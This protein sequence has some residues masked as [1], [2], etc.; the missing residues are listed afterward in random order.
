MTQRQ[1][2]KGG[3]IT[4]N[5]TDPTATVATG[6]WGLIDAAVNAPNN[7]WPT[8]PDAPTMGTVALVGGNGA[9]VPFTLGNLHGATYVETTVT[10][11]C[12]AF[13]A[14]GTSSPLSISGLN[15]GTSYTFTGTT[16]ST[17][18]VSGVSAPSNSVTA[19][20]ATGQQLYGTPG[21]YS[22]TAPTG[23]TKVSVIAVG[24]GANGGLGG[25][26]SSGAGGGGGAL[27]YTNNLTVTPGAGYTVV[28]GATGTGGT[29]CTAPGQAS[30]FA[31]NPIAGGGNLTN[32]HS[33]G[34][35]GTVTVGTGASGGSGGS[36]SLGGGIDRSGGGGGAAGYTGNG[37]NGGG[38]F[39][40]GSAAAACSGGGGGGGGRGGGGSNNPAGRGGG[41]GVLGKGSTGAGGS[42]GSSPQAGGNG[43]GGSY[44]AGGAGGG[45]AKFG[46]GTS[47]AVRII[48]PGC[49]RSFPST[50][51]GNL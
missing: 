1:R 18:G 10:S 21:T 49:A 12:G 32:R 8:I 33:G 24:G 7:T 34:A 37:G 44:G 41:V 48:W 29:V 28:V 38:S 27:A 50:C 6:V 9:S 11:N 23:V 47:G 26:A 30:S 40:N 35:G 22:W 17:V 51:T 19:T 3:F 13:S 36:G 39:S 15:P 46:F 31:S 5:E 42:D 25:G 4:K 2:Y 16:T 20:V 14:T 45:D 43:S